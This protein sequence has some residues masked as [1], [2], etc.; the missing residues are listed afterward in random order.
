M[1]AHIKQQR[2]GK[3]ALGKVIKED[4]VGKEEEDVTMTPTQE[5]DNM[6]TQQPFATIIDKGKIYTNQT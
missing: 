2:K 4:T 6:K 5:E 3:K 1:S